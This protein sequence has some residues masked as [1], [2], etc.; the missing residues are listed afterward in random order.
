MSR[1]TE[2][3]RGILEGIK[4]YY[5]PEDTDNSYTHVIELASPKLFDFSF[6]IFDE[7]YR[8]VLITKFCKHFYQREIG[9]ET[10][11]QFKLKLDEKLNLI[12]PYYNMLY[13]QSIE[14]LDLFKTSDM[15]TEHS[16]EKSGDIVNEGNATSSGESKSVNMFSD[17][18]QGTIANVDSGTYLTDVTVNNANDSTESEQKNTQTINTMDSYIEHRYGREGLNPIDQ[19]LKMQETFFSIDNMILEKC[20]ELFMQIW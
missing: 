9:L 10:V 17:T 5:Y 3:I 19:L 20:E 1:Y 14:G 8:Q 2:Q 7:S 16:L 11:G 18:P 6:P 15:H 13:K 12:M 4:R